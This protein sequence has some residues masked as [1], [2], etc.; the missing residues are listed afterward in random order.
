MGA[1]TSREGST[2]RKYRRKL[3]SLKSQKSRE[4]MTIDNNK[5][6]ESTKPISAPA[7][8]RVHQSTPVNLVKHQVVLS[9]HVSPMSSLSAVISIPMRR[10]SWRKSVNT[11]TTRTTNDNGSI[12]SSSFFD[13]DINDDAD[14]EVISSPR[15]S[16]GSEENNF[17]KADEGSSKKKI[18]PKNTA[19]PLNSFKSSYKKEG[20]DIVFE[21]KYNTSASPTACTS[22][23]EEIP[24][25][26][27]RPFWS[28][29]NGDEREYERQLRQHYVLKHVLDGNIHV[30]IP[31]D[32]S[33]TILDS[34]CGAGFWTSD[35]AQAY[36]NAKVIGLDAFP[37][38]DKRMKGYS[39]A[40]ISAPN[41]VYKY[42]DLTTQLTLPDDYVDV[43]YQRDTTS[44]IPHERWPFL[45]EELMRVT[46]PGGYVEFVEY[47]FD[48]RDPGPVLAL[49]NE[50]YKIA[51]TSVGV[52]P[53]EAR[54]LE[55]KLISAGFQHVEK[56]VVSI[57]IG[58]WPN[59]KD[60]REKGFLYKQV[61]K[62]LF[63]SMKPWWITE[64]GVTEQEYDKV[65]IAAMDEFDEQQCYID[66]MIYTAKKPLEITANHTAATATTTAISN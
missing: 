37:A 50:W 15:T 54:Q 27:P 63:K 16:V 44:I 52:D 32:K 53:K 4:I 34:A 40:T 22:P 5:P 12:T 25:G 43:L 13:D 1:S 36:P 10:S 42:G 59:E 64:L 58:E 35:M 23:Q 48:I 65:V 49:V 6:T 66:W 38:D 2:R 24:K 62:T 17:S 56:K 33:L 7:S 57:P 31:T 20:N 28:Y 39:N 41:I 30:P 60:Q 55:S 29:N 18:R 9:D 26:P 11:F 61:I 19:T 8:F 14:F 47:D 51:S 21:S 46:K 45:L 3:A